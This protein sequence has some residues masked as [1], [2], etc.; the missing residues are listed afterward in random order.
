MLAP[1]E[2]RCI[3]S[4]PAAMVVSTSPVMIA[5]AQSSRAAIAEAHC[6]STPLQATLSGSPLASQASLL[7]TFCAPDWLAQPTITTSMSSGFTAL[8]RSN[9]AS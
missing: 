6:I 1:I 7:T 3:I 8:L 2:T 5:R 9:S 4:T